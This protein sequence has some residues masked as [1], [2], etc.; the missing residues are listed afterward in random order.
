MHKPANIFYQKI[1]HSKWSLF[2]ICV[3]RS[4]NNIDVDKIAS[5]FV[6]KNTLCEMEKKELRVNESLCRVPPKTR[7][8][9]NPPSTSCLLYVVFQIVPEFN[10]NGHQAER[11]SCEFVCLF[12]LWDIWGS[13]VYTAIQQFKEKARELSE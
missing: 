6:N 11:S 7:T 5:F 4:T 2:C 3:G 9:F 1:F 12:F 10:K 8:N 13:C